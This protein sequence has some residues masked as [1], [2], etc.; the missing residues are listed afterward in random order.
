MRLEGRLP[1]FANVVYFEDEVNHS[2]LYKGALHHRPHYSFRSRISA[3][4]PQFE[5]E[6]Q[7]VF[8]QRYLGFFKLVVWFLELCFIKIGVQ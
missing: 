2:T 3:P 5:F 8:P 1:A 4:S 7:L 6:A